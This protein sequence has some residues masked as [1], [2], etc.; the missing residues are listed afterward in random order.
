MAST[1]EP[2]HSENYLGMN[3]FPSMIHQVMTAKVFNQSPHPITQ[4]IHL[5]QWLMKHHL[6][7]HHH[8]LKWHQLAKWP[9][10]QQCHCTTPH[11]PNNG[12]D[13]LIK[14]SVL[15]KRICLFEEQSVC[16]LVTYNIV[17]SIYD[18]SLYRFKFQLFPVFIVLALTC[19]YTLYLLSQVIPYGQRWS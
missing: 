4:L 6:V 9:R 2:S 10:V 3:T 1:P 13:D 14:E 12:L 17:L 7:K 18:L 11:H 16:L 5:K 15:Q 8:C 19:I